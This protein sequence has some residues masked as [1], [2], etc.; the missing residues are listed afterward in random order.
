[1]FRDSKIYLF[2]AFA[3]ILSLP[4]VVLPAQ[5]HS[6]YARTLYDLRLARVLL[7]R[8]S[9]AQTLNNSLDE[10]NIAIDNI[11]SAIAEINRGSVEQSTNRNDILRVDA[12]MLWAARLSKSLELI[13]KAQHDCS[14]QKEIPETEGLQARVLGQIDQ[15]HSRL[16]VALA[17]IN[18]DYSAR[19]MS[20]RDD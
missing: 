19:S 4:R 20:T 17:T 3:L 16:R 6:D 18:F 15:A 1:V 11:D 12:R 10:V 5:R 2:A 9:E 8:T 13:E 14:K 7:Q